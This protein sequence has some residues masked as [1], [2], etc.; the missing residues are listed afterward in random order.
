MS[1]EQKARRAWA[2][3]RRR[4]A[5]EV[6]VEGEGAVAKSHARGISGESWSHLRRWEARRR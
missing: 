3:W 6:N 1:R 2:I 4:G 5:E